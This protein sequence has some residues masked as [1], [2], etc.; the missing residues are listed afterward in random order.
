MYKLE[1]LDL[2]YNMLSGKIPTEIGYMNRLRHLYLHNNQFDGRIPAELA[3]PL[4]VTLQ[5][6]NNPGLVGGMPLEICALHGATLVGLGFLINVIGDCYIGECVL[7]IETDVDN[8]NDNDNNE[9][10]PCPCLCCSE[11]Y[12][13]CCYGDGGVCPGFG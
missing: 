7:D 6:Q 1:K 9:P 3:L 10:I 12:T 5:L 13:P 8:D 4:M 2:S 11:G